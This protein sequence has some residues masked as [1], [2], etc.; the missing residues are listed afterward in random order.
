MGYKHNLGTECFL[1]GKKRKFMDMTQATSDLVEALVDNG[2]VTWSQ[3]VDLI[4]FDDDAKAFAAKFIE[5]GYGSHLVKPF[6]IPKTTNPADQ[7]IALSPGELAQ[8]M[9]GLRPDGIAPLAERTIQMT[10][11]NFAGLIGVVAV[12]SA[13]DNKEIAA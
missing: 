3:L 10:I 9:A 11:G 13:F 7:L 5:A 4:H 2:D 1:P 12:A 8:Y 6:L